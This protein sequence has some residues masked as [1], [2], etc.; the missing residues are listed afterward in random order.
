M[1]NRFW[2]VSYRNRDNG[3]RITAAVFA[4][5]QQQAQEKARADGRIDGRDVWEIESIEPH[6]E[7]LARVLIAEFSKKQQDGHF[8]CPRCGKMAMDAESVTRNAL[9]RR[10]TVYICDACG[11]QEALEDM[12]DSITP[13]TAWAIAAAPE[14]W[15]MR[16]HYS[17][18]AWAREQY[19]DR[20]NDCPYFR[21]MV[22]RGEIP[23]DYIGRRTVMIHAPIKGTVLLTEGYHFTVDDEEGRQYL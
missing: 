17:A 10:A 20:W 21:D 13:L 1:E 11:M 18:A 3:Q 15:R 7:T 14:N 8:A 4:A 6:E 5:D 9:S 22:E 16:R 12:M 23:A 19:T 2:T